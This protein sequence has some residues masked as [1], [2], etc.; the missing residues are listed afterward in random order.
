[1]SDDWDREDWGCQFTREITTIYSMHVETCS[2]RIETA[3]FRNVLF[4]W[5]QFIVI[6]PKAGGVLDVDV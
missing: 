6:G 4:K 5:R 1:M 2:Q 3:S